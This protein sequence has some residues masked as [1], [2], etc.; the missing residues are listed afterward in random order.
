MR[1][2]FLLLALILLAQRPAALAQGQVSVIMAPVDGID[3]TPDNLL[4]FQILS[5]LDRPSRALIKGSLRYRNSPL[6]FA[7]QF[8]HTLQPGLNLLADKGLRPSIIYSSPALRELFEYHKKLPE[9]LYE[10]C[11]SVRPDY[12]SPE[13]DAHVY[14]EC[15]YHR[16]D[17]VF[18]IELL[19]PE[20]DAKLYEYYPMLSWTVNY[21]FAHELS[22]RLRVAEVKEGQNN[23][24]ALTRNNLMLDEK[25]LAQTG[26]LY[27]TYAKPLEKFKPYAWTVDAYYKGI[28]IGGAAPW[29]FT[30]IEDSLIAPRMV[31]P[32]Y[33]DIAKE[34]GKY[35]L[36]A[37]GLIK[38]KYKLE[39]L[40]SDT[41][42][43]TLYDDAGKT[44]PLRDNTWNA[45]YGDNRYVIDF[46]EEERPLKHAQYYMLVIESLTG[47]TFKISFQYSNPDLTK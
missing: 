15:T 1:T 3:L 32:S 41:L 36:Y 14:D 12:V 10:Y 34:G 44:L 42:R 20:N 8:E 16:S 19:D 18:L 47:R 22:Y 31:D 37:P 40:T 28:L 39:D 6:S 30:I 27:P 35:G 7:F 17:D 38:L 24:T 21:P 46:K 2:S 25:N 23:I 43:M 45:R 11:V 29:R 33:I 13:G 4:S 26:T 9:G 5:Q